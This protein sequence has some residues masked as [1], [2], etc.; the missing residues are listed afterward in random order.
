MALVELCKLDSKVSL[1]PYQR[2]EESTEPG[3]LDMNFINPQQLALPP[4]GNVSI[5]SDLRFCIH[6]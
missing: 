5:E 2:E 1:R 6:Y 3:H 4:V